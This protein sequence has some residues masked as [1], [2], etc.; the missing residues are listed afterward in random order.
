[1][2]K[3]AKLELSAIYLMAAL[4]V[5]SVASLVGKVVTAEAMENYPQLRVTPIAAH[6]QP[7]GKTVYLTFDD[8]PS[9]NTEKVLDVLLEK[10]AKAT[11][12]VTAQNFDADYAPVMLQRMVDEGHAVALHTYSHKVGE[13]YRSVDSF[14]ADLNKLND[15]LYETI[16]VRPK[17]LR[18]AGGSAT[19]NCAPQTM[20]AIIEEITD[21][22]YQ[23]YDWDV[24]SGDDTPQA[25][26]AETIA[27]VVIDGAKKKE[28]VII[29]LHDNPAATTTPAAVAQIIDTLRADGY[30]FACLTEEVE[31]VHT[32][33]NR[34]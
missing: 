31:P 33:T 21:R 28:Q 6:S 18:F 25:K 17:I 16:G 11:F 26:P 23:F 14:L 10:D 13:I 5:L 8:G 34:F 29:L 20:K 30:N 4:L 3:F 9:K 22:G 2:K 1:M 32:H 12:F 15:Y 24:V 27:K 7:T 19:V